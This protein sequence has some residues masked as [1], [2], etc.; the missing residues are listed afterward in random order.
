MP[1]ANMN[2]HQIKLIRNIF[3]SQHVE[4]VKNKVFT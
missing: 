1:L 2:V 3:L 4:I